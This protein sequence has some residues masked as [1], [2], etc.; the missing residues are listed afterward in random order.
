MQFRWWMTAALAMGLWAQEKPAFEVASVKAH[1][2]GD[3]SFSFDIAQSGRVSAR[4]MTVWNLI[5]SAY[6]LKDGEIAGGPGWV[7]TQGFDIDAK[8][9]GDAPVERKQA[10]AML[11]ALLEERFAMRS[12][13]ETREQAGYELVVDKGGA[14]LAPAGE[15]RALLKFGDLNDP[16][17]T[18]ASLCQILEFDV[19]RPVVN[20]TG[21]DGPYAIQLRWATDRAPKT[22]AAANDG[23]PS[24]FTA[25]RE[26][27]GL[28]MENAKVPVGVLVID[29]V[30]MPSGN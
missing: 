18:L 19:A 14:K 11:G 12:H 10:Q 30:A 17:M 6:G 20:K 15:G 2:G 4:N 25:V 21:L 7:K 9:E 27:L 1:E 5:R 24:L 8:P 29:S 16:K 13:R 23:L 3:G 22:D 26:T 28:R